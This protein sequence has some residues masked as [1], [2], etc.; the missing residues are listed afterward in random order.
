[1]T[2]DYREQ[3]TTSITPIEVSQIL[4]VASAPPF[5]PTSLFYDA[6][7]GAGD[8]YFTQ[9]DFSRTNDRNH[10]AKVGITAVG[11]G[12]TSAPTITQITFASP[13]SVALR[14][15]PF[16]RSLLPASEVFYQLTLPGGASDQVIGDGGGAYLA[17]N[18]V[19]TLRAK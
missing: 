8:E 13:T 1:M 3:F 12:T 15:E 7:T 11:P 10:I 19:L 5:S 9:I 14:F 4:A 6:T 16:T 17:V 2:A 18:I